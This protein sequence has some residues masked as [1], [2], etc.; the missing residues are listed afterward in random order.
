MV[1]TVR[2]VL[3]TILWVAAGLLT[4][5]LVFS[6]WWIFAPFAFASGGGGNVLVLILAIGALAIAA[7]LI[8][9]RTQG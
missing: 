4:L 3:A 6:G 1:W 7:H 5:F 8:G 9:R 2:S